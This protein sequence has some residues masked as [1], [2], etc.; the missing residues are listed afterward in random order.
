MTGNMICRGVPF[1]GTTN[2]YDHFVNDSFK[3]DS[4]M[5]KG[6]INIVLVM[7]TMSGPFFAILG[8]CFGYF[9]H[10]FIFIYLK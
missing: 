6:L 2:I 3:M 10:I 8:P 4:Y 1:K 9:S 7:R 5:V